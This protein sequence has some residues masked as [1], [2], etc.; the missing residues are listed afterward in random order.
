MDSFGKD[1][2]GLGPTEGADRFC[3]AP[4]CTVFIMIIAVIGDERWAGGYGVDADFVAVENTHV[5]FVETR[6]IRVLFAA[7]LSLCCIVAV[8]LLYIIAWRLS[9]RAT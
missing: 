3:N 8:L 1:I 6:D 9:R 2:T 5:A 7:V 4:R